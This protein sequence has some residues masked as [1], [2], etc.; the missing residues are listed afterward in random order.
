MHAS[1]IQH[2]ITLLIINMFPPQQENSF[3]LICG[4]KDWNVIIVQQFIQSQCVGSSSLDADS[5][6]CCNEAEDWHA[7]QY[8]CQ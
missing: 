2:Q 3:D 7:V 8:I 5:F 1:V 6:R 4:S